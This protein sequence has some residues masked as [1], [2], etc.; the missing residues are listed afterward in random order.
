MTKK[1]QFD[2]KKF[3]VKED[4]KVDL[5]ELPTKAGKEFKGKPEGLAA[6]SVDNEY[7]HEAQSRL[8]ASGERALLIILQGMDA[9][10]KDG[11]IEHVMH[12]I[13]PQG[14]RVHSFKAPNDEELQHHFLWRPMRFLPAR[15]MVT[16]FN[17]SYYEEVMVVRVHPEFLQPQKLP[18][19]KK[20]GDLWKQRYEE[21]R[22]FEETLVASGTS[23][24]KFFLHV[25][26][27]EQKSRLME[28]LVDPNKRWKFNER[29]LDERQL[30]SEHQKADEEALAATSTKKAPWF[31]IPAD[32]KWYARAAIADI[33][34]SHVESLGLS[35][36][37]VPKSE[38]P[39]FAEMIERL[40]NEK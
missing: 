9:A 35:Y 39:H 17:R 27:E 28:R 10:G 22:S 8:Y 21:I 37:K 26:K 20:L 6:L 29:D 25:S 30:W 24:I 11:V 3:R 2:H 34:V 40:E 33:I 18:P 15:G 38:E 14:C 5:S 32:D 23:V 16:I 13:N 36:P 4:S 1:H 19:M 31:V 12:G 7:L